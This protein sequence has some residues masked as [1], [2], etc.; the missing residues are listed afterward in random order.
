LWLALRLQTLAD[1]VLIDFAGV[2]ATASRSVRNALPWAKVIALSHDTHRAYLRLLRRLI[3][4]LLE[5]LIE[6][7]RGPGASSPIRMI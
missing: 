1:L 6:A 7:I 4:R 2:E 5:G 3:D